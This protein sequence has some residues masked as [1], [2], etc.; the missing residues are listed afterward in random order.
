MGELEQLIHVQ[1]L[2]Q[3]P[4]HAKHSPNKRQTKNEPKFD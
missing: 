1:H 3:H 2:E 4:T